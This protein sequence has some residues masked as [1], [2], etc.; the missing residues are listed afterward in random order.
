MRALPAWDQPEDVRRWVEN[1]RGPRADVDPRR[2]AAAFVEE[3]RTAAGEV[4]PVATLFLTNRECPFRCLMCDLWKHTLPSRVAL[5]AIPEQVRMA[6]STLPPARAIKLY[7]SGSYF[8][9]QAIPPEDDAEIAQLTAGFERV[10]V[11]CHPA[12]LGERCLGFQQLIS[13]ELEV[14]VGLETVHPEILRRLNKGMTLKS[15]HRAAEFLRRHAIA[16][17]CF[18]LLRPPFLSEEEGVEWAI[19]SIE[20]A[21][22]S[23][24]AACTIIPTRSGNGAMDLLQKQGIF[25]PPSLNSLETVLEAG[26]GM[27][28]GRVFAD[29]W[30]LGAFSDCPSCFQG[31]L[32]RLRQMNLTGRVSTGSLCT[33]CGW[34]GRR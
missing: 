19:K 9:P 6:L 14:A 17:R 12:F 4:I 11:E 31:R 33:A 25:A 28:R 5:G 1:L 30:D 22:D 8:D 2:A 13:G 16:M 3:E 18:I 20:V 32:E 24:A 26:I 15:F 34:S 21:F 27:Q 29:L 7:N 23:G 10:I